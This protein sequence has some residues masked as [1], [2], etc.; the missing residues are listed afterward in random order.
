MIPANVAIHFSALADGSMSKAVDDEQ[1]D[2]NR[3]VFLAQRG[4]IPEKTAL[5]HLLYEGDDYCRYHAIGQAEAGD[6]MVRESTIVADALFTK[7]KNLALLLPVADCIG[8]VLYDP[9]NEVLGLAHLG[10]HNIEQNGGFETVRYM[11]DQ[12]GAKPSELEIWLSPAA[13]KNNY[14]LYDF[15]NRSMH[16]VAHEQ[17]LA[18][19]VPAA[20]ITHDERDTTT[21]PALF[22]HSEFLKGNRPTDGRQAVVAMMR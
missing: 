12:F 21:D 10:R 11:R 6:G 9:T 7:E 8:V 18:A 16:D 4:I 20:N 19:G 22:S 5:V 17:L 14:P 15:N 2:E 1:R 13:G 3:R